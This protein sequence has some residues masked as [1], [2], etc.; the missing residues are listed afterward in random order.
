MGTG[1]VRKGNSMTYRHDITMAIFQVRDCHKY[2]AF[3]IEI[4]MLFCTS[5]KDK[6]TLTCK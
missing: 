1:Y 5:L 2:V 6:F 3:K 4:Q